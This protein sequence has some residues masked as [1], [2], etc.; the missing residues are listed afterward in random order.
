MGEEARGAE[1]ADTGAC[2][3]AG[4]GRRIRG[5]KQGRQIGDAQRGGGNEE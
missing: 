3:M 2:G 1:R 5:E 4:W